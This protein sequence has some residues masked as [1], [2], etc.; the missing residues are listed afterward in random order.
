MNDKIINRYLS[1]LLITFIFFIGVASRA[2]NLNF[3]DFWTDEIFGFWTSD[4]N[5]IFEETL[6]RTLNSNFNFLFD[7]ILK[8]FHSIFG[9]N[10][11]ISR[12]LPLTIS[13]LSL[14]L[15]LF[16]FKK[17][18]NTPSLIF[19]FFLLS[20]NI[21]HIKFSVEIR[22]YI[23]TFFLTIIFFM[24]NFKQ[25]KLVDI[26]FLRLIGILFISILMIFNHSFTLLIIFSLVVFRIAHSYLNNKHNLKD[27]ILIGGLI[28]L[29]LLYLFLYLPLNIKF[30]GSDFFTGE[31]FSPHWMKQVKP[32]FFTNF[33]F[34]QFFGSRILGLIYLIILIY[35]IFKFK[36]YL[37][38]KFNIYSFFV[39]LILFSYSIPLLYSFLIGPVLLGRF[40]IYLLI[41]IIS[42]IAFLTFKIKNKILKYFIIFILVT[43]TTVN[44][45]LYENS[46]KQFY[47]EIYPTKPQ[48][49][50]ALELINTSGTKSFI[51]MDNKAKEKNSY[52]AY[53]NYI[54]NYKK[55]LRYNLDYFN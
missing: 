50:E 3:E 22:S 25:K 2:Y 42:I 1:Y 32:S 34:S 31:S 6:L 38:K 27:Y 28:S 43:P 53:E 45:I 13:I 35:L 17:I 40:L 33:Y 10:V 23:L 36:E 37:V 14:I 52:I 12:F 8:F 51:L 26:N 30:I 29:G 21:F 47:K 19:G 7:F 46:F 24:L 41:P 49:G 39:V 18:S 16:F 20:I 55:S 11:H 9:Y 44:H 4:P 48:I 15:Y 54:L 5:I